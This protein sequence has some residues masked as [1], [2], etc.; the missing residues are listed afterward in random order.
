MKIV[1]QMGREFHLKDTPQRVISLVPSITEYLIDIG[2]EVVGR[3]KFCIHPSDKVS[4][5]KVIG[6]TKNFRFD[7][8]KELQPDLIIGNKEENFEAGINQLAENHPVWMSDI[9][10]L[11]D[12]FD[13]MTR[14]G[15]MLNRKQ[16]AENEVLQV[17]ENL[18]KYKN[19]KNG[20]AVYLIWA[21]P[22]MAAGQGTFISNLLSYV[23][24]G[25]TITEERYPVLTKE[26]LT[27]INP[28]KVLLSSEPFPFKS[29]HVDELKSLLPNAE[30]LPVNGEAYSWYGSR[31]SKM[32]F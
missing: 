14:L 21:N 30:I 11:E 4:T 19:T 12:S 20:K 5:I 23:G 17:S 26:V 7:V 18:S 8:I 24:Y 28:D 3:T 31:L 9:S 13:M 10:T 15:Q 25:N 29:K 1:D 32:V 22:W 27:H 6:G 2:V 16:A